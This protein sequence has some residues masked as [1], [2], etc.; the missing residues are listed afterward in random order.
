MSIITSSRPGRQ[1]IPKPQPFNPQFTSKMDQTEPKPSGNNFASHP[2]LINPPFES[3]TLQNEQ[4]VLQNQ[5][6]KESSSLFYKYYYNSTPNN[7]CQARGL[8]TGNV[9][10]TS[11]CVINC[12]RGN[13]PS[14]MC[15]PE[16]AK[17]INI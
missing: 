9:D 13:C 10:M 8:W 7:S 17:N 16:C 11:W 2:G 4:N 5:V 14:T 12:K 15:S 1:D 6:K 3:K